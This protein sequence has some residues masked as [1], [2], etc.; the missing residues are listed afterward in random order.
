MPAFLESFLESHGGRLGS[1][2]TGGSLGQERSSSEAVAP[3]QESQLYHLE[4]Q[5]LGQVT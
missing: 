1:E 2:G 5:D 3:G 4:L